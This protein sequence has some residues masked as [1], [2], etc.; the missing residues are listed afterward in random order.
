MTTQRFRIFALYNP[1]QQ[2][3]YTLSWKHES[4]FRTTADVTWFISCSIPVLLNTFISQRDFTPL[5]RLYAIKQATSSQLTHSIHR[6][7]APTNTNHKRLQNIR[8]AHTKLQRIE[9]SLGVHWTHT[10]DNQ[11][12]STRCEITALGLIRLATIDF[13]LN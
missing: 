11:I 4:L 3:L 10:H 9:R 6:G 8:A 5:Q 1:A 12:F 2:H 13:H 7:S